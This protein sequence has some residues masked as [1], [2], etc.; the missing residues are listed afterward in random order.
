MNDEEWLLALD[1]PVVLG[2]L[3]Y[4]PWHQEPALAQHS[5]SAYVT[6]IAVTRTARGAGVA[7]L[8]YDALE[9][10]A[11]ERS[12]PYLSTR[13]WSTNTE[14]IRMLN[15]R[16]FEEVLRR[17]D[18]RAPGIDTLYFAVSVRAGR[19][20][21]SARPDVRPLARESVSAIER[22]QTGDGSGTRPSGGC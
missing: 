16:G 13:T 9:Q 1:G 4:L 5:P 3:S 14:H 11:F 15:R 10:T 7:T 6:T 8:L 19:R 22:P 12:L 17:V 18:E 2:L 20:G 21:S